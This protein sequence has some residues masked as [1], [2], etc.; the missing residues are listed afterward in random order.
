MA[1]LVNRFLVRFIDADRLFN[2]Y[3]SQSIYGG[4]L[5]QRSS[6]V[7]ISFCLV[8]RLHLVMR[9]TRRLLVRRTPPAPRATNSSSWNS[10]QTYEYIIRFSEQLL[11]L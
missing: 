6:S 4:E 2:Y 11:G 10:E 5:K 9:D 7:N 3:L 1:G 8:T